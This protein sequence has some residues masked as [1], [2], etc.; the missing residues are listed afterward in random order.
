MNFGNPLW[1]VFK[2]VLMQTAPCP[3]PDSSRTAV[4]DTHPIRPLPRKKA[5]QLLPSFLRAH[6]LNLLLSRSIFSVPKCL[7]WGLILC[8]KVSKGSFSLCNSCRLPGHGAAHG[9]AHGA[10]FSKPP[11]HIHNSR[12]SLQQACKTLFAPLVQ[13]FL[14]IT[15]CQI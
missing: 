7:I 2:P 12:N 5:N 9:A 3:S 1:H 14:K 15:P 10:S 4:S 13:I 6:V 11:F 8:L